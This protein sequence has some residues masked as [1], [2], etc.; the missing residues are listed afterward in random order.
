MKDIKETRERINEIDKEMVKLFE[1]RM[2]EAKEV[3]L[4]KR[5]NNLPIFDKER[6]DEVLA[7]NSELIENK[8][9]VKYYEEFME[10]L[11]NTSKKYQEDLKR[12][13]ET[14]RSSSLKI[15]HVNTDKE[16][17]ILVGKNILKNFDK[18]THINR[19]VLLVTDEN[20]PREYAKS[21]EKESKELFYYVIKPGEKSKNIDN[22]KAILELMTNN[23]FSRKD[24]VIALGGGVVG[25]LA[26]FAASTYMRGIDFYNIPT[27]LLAMVDSSIGGKCA[28]DFLGIKNIVG[29]FYQPNKVIIDIDTLK[30][31][32]KREFNAG[33]VEA[34]K[35]A[36]CF[37]KE[38]AALILRDPNIENNID[39]VIVSSINI[40]KRVVEE[41]TYESGLRKVL[42]YGHTLGH[43]IEAIESPKLL[44]GEAVAQGM[45]FASSK[46]VCKLV[47]LFI[48]KYGL[49]KPQAL[50][51]AKIMEYIKHDKKSNQDRIDF[52]YL[53][54][55]TN[56]EIQNIT[57]KE[58]EERL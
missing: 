23:H 51:K 11:M 16:Y 30:T 26:G 38:L 46:E 20:I 37:D 36:L 47:N 53:K 19:K 43:A 54:S 39:K 42:N 27:S 24:V 21:I 14:P 4:Y 28:I 44:H 41:D 12:A 6:E 56:F 5:E 22:Y 50:D 52:I 10:N 58:L 25:D 40:K 18:F 7:H 32:P 2:A 31:L 9:Y 17:D 57:L 35:M 29:S 33:L 13:D 3:F 8:E 49:P 34:F 48:A 15:I 1:E 45:L 55:T